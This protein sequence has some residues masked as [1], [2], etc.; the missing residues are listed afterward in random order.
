MPLQIDG[1]ALGELRYGENL[2]PIGEARIWDDGRWKTVYESWKPRIV[3]IATGWETWEDIVSGDATLVEWIA[4]INGPRFTA[5]VVADKDLRNYPAGTV[6]PVGVT[7]GSPPNGA[8]NTVV[9][10]TEVRP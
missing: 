5:P 6:I 3:T 1:K 4:T 10:F 8:F 2:T 9:T 7:P